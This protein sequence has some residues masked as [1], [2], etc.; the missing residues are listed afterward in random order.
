MG[1]CPHWGHLIPLFPWTKDIHLSI[2]K[3]RWY[4]L[5]TQQYIRERKQLGISY[6]ELSY[7][8]S[9]VELLESNERDRGEAPFISLHLE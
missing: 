6:A 2:W 4:K 8:R 9:L 3:L 1:P 5:F 7:L